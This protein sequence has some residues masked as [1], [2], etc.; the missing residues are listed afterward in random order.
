MHLFCFFLVAIMASLS[1]GFGSENPAHL[2]TTSSKEL[3]DASI[4]DIPAE[5][6]WVE[7]ERAI[8]AP[9]HGQWEWRK[10][11]GSLLDKEKRL[12]MTVCVTEDRTVLEDTLNEVSIRL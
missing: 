11:E 3:K 5:E 1:F 6:A 2:D 10:A 12:R 4:S 9:S 7:K 8:L